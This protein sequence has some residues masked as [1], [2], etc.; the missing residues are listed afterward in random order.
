MC[1]FLWGGEG[2][3]PCWKYIQNTSCKEHLVFS[4]YFLPGCA[5]VSAE[6]YQSTAL[7]LFTVLIFSSVLSPLTGL[8]IWEKVNWNYTF[9]KRPAKD[10]SHP[11]FLPILHGLFL[12]RCLWNSRGEHRQLAGRGLR[13]LPAQAA[14]AWEPSVPARGLLHCWGTERARPSGQ[15]WSRLCFPAEMAGN[16]QSK[17]FIISNM[18]RWVNIN[19]LNI[20]ILNAMEWQI[21]I[22]FVISVVTCSSW[23]ASCSV[24]SEQCVGRLTWRR[25]AYW[26]VLTGDH[27]KSIA[28]KGRELYGAGKQ[29]LQGSLS[30]RPGLRSLRRKAGAEP[31]LVSAL[32]PPCLL[33][34]QGNP[35]TLCC[36]PVPALHQL[37]C[38]RGCR[39]KWDQM[40]AFLHL[41]VREPDLWPRSS[42]PACLRHNGR[43]AGLGLRASHQ[44]GAALSHR[45]ALL[46]RCH[47]HRSCPMALPGSPP[48]CRG[49]SWRLQELLHRSRGLLPLG[50]R[51]RGCRQPS[52]DSWLKSEFSSFLH[53]LQQNSELDI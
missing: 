14:L 28:R 26:S 6:H 10:T 53:F 8:C 12:F 18:K 9:V 47:C 35:A 32:L 2:R 24:M 30:H 17:Y 27:S 7:I 38:G 13:E 23:A 40:S 42:I 49:G 46:P 52:K 33:G 19:V 39:R 25:L 16:I 51:L 15:T 3:N 21:C 29:R 44:P 1:L 11:L 22:S 4:N 41:H 37:I 34:G 50:F 48:R 5:G 20:S 45:A 31:G 43:A 36:A